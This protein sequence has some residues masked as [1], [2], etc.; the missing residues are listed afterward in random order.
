VLRGVK[1]KSLAWEVTMRRRHPIGE[2]TRRRAL[3][4]AGGLG[5]AP[6]SAGLST[7]AEPIATGN[8]TTIGVGALVP[9]ESNDIKGLFQTAITET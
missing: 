1:S 9:Q 8:T 4:L 7:A 5:T 3:M 6:F 2:L